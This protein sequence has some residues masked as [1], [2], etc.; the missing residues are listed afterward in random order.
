M[1]SGVSA[2]ETI[3]LTVSC[4]F[5]GDAEAAATADRQARTGKVTTKALPTAD[6]NG[7][8]R[9]A[10]HLSGLVDGSMSPPP[11]SGRY[12]RR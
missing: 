7:S 4:R 1:L 2:A 8:V 10:C 9:F 12:A 6:A 11:S 5:S 3:G